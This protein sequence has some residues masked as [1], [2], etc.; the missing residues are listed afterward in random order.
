[1]AE[2]VKDPD[3]G[4][5][6]VRRCLDFSLKPLSDHCW[7]LVQRLGWLPPHGMGDGG[8]PIPY[9]AVSVGADSMA[10]AGHKVA[11]HLSEGGES[12]GGV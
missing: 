5:G 8:Y 7:S 6:L 9:A 11:V 12:G 10:G 2:N 3:K 4:G 1:M